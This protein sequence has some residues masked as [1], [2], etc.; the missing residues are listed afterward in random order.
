MDNSR[1][2]TGGS[3]VH[4]APNEKIDES[5]AQTLAADVERWCRHRWLVIYLPYH[6]VFAAFPMYAMEAHIPVEGRSPREVWQH[7]TQADEFL[8]AV[9]VQEMTVASITAL[10]ISFDGRRGAAG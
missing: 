4:T 2:E 5:K 8:A 1:A 3:G 6:R 9:A 10:R 7:I